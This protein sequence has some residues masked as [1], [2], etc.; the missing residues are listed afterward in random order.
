MGPSACKRGL[1]SIVNPREKK[2][3]W[4][5]LF[6]FA[7]WFT[8]RNK[9]GFHALGPI[10]WRVWI[11]RIVLCY[12]MWRLSLLLDFVIYFSNLFADL[13]K[14][15]QCWFV[16]GWRDR[17]DGSEGHEPRGRGAAT[18]AV[19][20]ANLGDSRAKAEETLGGVQQPGRFRVWKVRAVQPAR[21]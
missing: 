12:K 14:Y 8:M 3:Q 16:T 17:D 20:G 7:P 10:V 9:L 15:S 21:G 19:L 2:K 5:L 13:N 4:P 18:R 6:F 11:W 1:W